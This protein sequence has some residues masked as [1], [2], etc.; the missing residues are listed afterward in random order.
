MIDLAAMMVIPSHVGALMLLVDRCPTPEARK[1]LIV[2]AGA[3]E[4]ITADEATLLISAYQL[5]SA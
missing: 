5:E 1:S 4:A 3:C 2:M